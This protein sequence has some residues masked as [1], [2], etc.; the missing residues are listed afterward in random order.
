MDGPRVGCAVRA[1]L[2]HRDVMHPDAGSVTV[3][4]KPDLRRLEDQFRKGFASG[5]RHD[6]D[7]CKLRSDVFRTI[8]TDPGFCFV[9]HQQKRKGWIIGGDQ[10]LVVEGV[11]QLGLER[12]ER[13]E[14][15]DPV[16]LV[17]LVRLE[18]EVNGQ[19]ISVDQATMG[20]RPPLAERS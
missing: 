8:R 13:S 20:L 10:E 12:L 1:V 11:F 3:V 16:P 7:L 2:A 14:V 9:K 17:Q 18:L 19:R 5:R 4:L 15:N 6:H